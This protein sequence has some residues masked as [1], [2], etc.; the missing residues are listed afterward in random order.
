MGLKGSVRARQIP[1]EPCQGLAEGQ[2]T[3]IPGQPILMMA[4][5]ESCSSLILHKSSSTAH[6]PH[7]PPALR[8]SFITGVSASA[9]RKAAIKD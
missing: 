5:I 1:S 6:T 4:A 3:A 2:A 8:K 7:R 9:G